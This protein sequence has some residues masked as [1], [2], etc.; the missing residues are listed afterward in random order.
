MALLS[1]SASSRGADIV[2]EARKWIGTPYMHQQKTCQQGCDCLGLVRGVWCALIGPEPENIPAYRP[3]WL[4]ARG[5]ERLW[6][7][8][9]RHFIE[10]A[11]D[12]D[13]IGDVLL[14]RMRTGHVAKHIGILGQDAQGHPTLIHAY[15]RYGV[16]EHALTKTWQRKIVAQFQFP[17]KD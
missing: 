8:G 14:F 7:V 12:L 3:D 17:Q 2:Q 9:R 10:R 1:R 4:E 6:A 15:Q 16:V 11:R 5:E 13:A